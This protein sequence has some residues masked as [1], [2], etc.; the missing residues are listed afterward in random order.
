[1]KRHERDSDTF[2]Q[3]SEEVN[4]GFA[5]EEVGEV[6]WFGTFVARVSQF[7]YRVDTLGFDVVE[8]YNSEEEAKSTFRYWNERY[9][10]W[11]EQQHEEDD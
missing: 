1:M 6:H 3:V 4:N 8:E 9:T 10:D 5:D 11:M 2:N 7:I